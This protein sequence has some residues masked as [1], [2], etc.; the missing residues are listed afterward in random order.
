MKFDY[1]IYAYIRGKNSN[2]APIGTPYYIGKGRGKRAFDNHGHH[3]LPEKQRIIFLETNLTEI[4]AL[5]LERRMIKWFGRIDMGTGILRNE[6][7]G[8]DG[9]TNP[10]EITKKKY[11]EAMKKVW[12]NRSKDEVTKIIKKILIKNDG[13]MSESAKEKLREIHKTRVYKKR[14]E[15]SKQRSSIARIKYL[16]QKK[17]KGNKNE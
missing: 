14:S 5:A 17:L 13:H 15:E 11:S 9:V 10:S 1:Y 12:A 3:A 2:I 7:D 6:T 16:N 8:G 4:G